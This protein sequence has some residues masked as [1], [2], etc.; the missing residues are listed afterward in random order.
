MFRQ[1]RVGDVT[2]V[3]ANA[4]YNRA[5]HRSPTLTDPGR[6]CG[7]RREQL[8]I[9]FRR[10]RNTDPPALVEVWNES[11]TNRGSYPHPTAGLLERW[12]FSRLHFDPN[13]LFVAVDSESSKIL[14]W[15]LA[16]FGPTPDLERQSPEVGV[17]CIV[18]VRPSAR[19]QGIGR[20]LVKACEEYLT[21]KGAK[22]LL[23]GPRWPNAPFGFGL[24]GGSNCPGFLDSD[25]NAAP[26]MKALGYVPAGRTLVFQKKLDQPL[27][28]ADPRFGMLRR[29]Y[30]T[31]MLR[32]ASVMTWWHDCVWGTLEPVEFRMIDKLTNIP[33]ARAIV[34]ELEG[35]SWRWGAPS[36]GL[37]D[38][39]VREDLRRQ[40]LAKLLVAQVMR[41]L[42]DQFFGILELQVAEE[43]PES[44]GLCKSLGFESVDAGTAYRKA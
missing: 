41:V 7:G 39:Q 5:D 43:Q 10:F 16:G 26:F 13:G 14:G 2:C 27:T 40:G 22:T 29:R 23:A 33:A 36:A 17:T 35:Y 28:L 25:P 18:L 1:D 30:E 37:F 11:L 9:T 8:V 20:G 6:R 15:A 24:Y 34:W 21:A 38:V 31:Q 3:T 42:Q 4:P 44:V 12:I 32:A 19:R